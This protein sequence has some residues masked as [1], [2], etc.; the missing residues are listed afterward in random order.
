M[1]ILRTEATLD[2]EKREALRRAF[3]ERTGQDCLVLDCGLTL[4]RVQVKK[5][6]PLFKR[7]FG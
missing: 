6:Q 4:E 7:L 5:E 1:Y 2:S 3:R